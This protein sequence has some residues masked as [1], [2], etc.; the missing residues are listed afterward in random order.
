MTRMAEE[1]VKF[2][3]V[4]NGS[5]RR[6][7]E[8]YFS[9]PCEDKIIFDDSV[10]DPKTNAIYFF[11]WDATFDQR[12]DKLLRV[13]AGNS[14]KLP[15]PQAFI[16]VLDFSSTLHSRSNYIFTHDLGTFYWQLKG[17]DRI[18][19]DLKQQK[20]FDRSVLDDDCVAEDSTG[21]TG[22]GEGDSD[23]V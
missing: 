3:Q 12:L 21:D 7:N 11:D 15:S 16:Y 8:A 10:F 18:R 14:G 23:N 17:I 20:D 5:H 1:D 13:E 4:I 9:S 2:I 19:K 22:T 6:M